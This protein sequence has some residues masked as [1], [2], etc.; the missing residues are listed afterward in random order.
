MSSQPV[1]A[2]RL[3]ITLCS[4]DDRKQIYSAR[5]EVYALELHQ[6]H[7]NKE[8]LLRDALDER[9]EYIVVRQ[10]AE[11]LGFVS[12][13]PPGG[14]YSVDKYFSRDKISVSFDQSLYE[15]RLLTVLSA[16]RGRIV[17]PLLMYGA[18]R[19]AESHGGSQLIAIGKREV[20]DMYARCG[21]QRT[22]KFAR[23]DAVEYELMTGHDRRRTRGASGDCPD[24][25]RF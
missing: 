22:G 10:G 13:T 7:S 2:Q 3:V 14:S 5:H 20:V 25:V 23:S 24:D 11:L 12:I 8:R 21:M 17:A 4:P 1:A 15:I 16:H 18:L 6:H 9:N 19:Y